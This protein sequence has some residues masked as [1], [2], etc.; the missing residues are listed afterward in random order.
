[1]VILN[2]LSF[3]IITYYG[4]KFLFNGGELR[5]PL[6]RDERMLLDGPEMFWC[7]T[8]STGLLAFSGNVGLDIMAVRL[9]VL[10]VFCIMGVCM[11]PNKPVWTWPLAMYVVYLIWIIAGCLYSPSFVYGFRVFLKYLYPLL[12]CLFASAAVC[13]IEVALKASLLARTVALVS[14]VFVM[15]LPLELMILPGVFWYA[16]ARCIHYISIMIL[17]LGLY[18]YTDQKKKNLFYFILFWVPCFFW[19]FRTSIMGSL[20]AVM[21]FYFIRYHIR[22]LPIIFGIIALGIASVFTIPSLRDKMFHGKNISLEDFRQGKVSNDDINTNA[23]A[24]MWESMENRFYK[25]HEIAGSGTGAV[26]NYMYNNFVFGGLRVVHSDFVQM[27][28]DNG[29]VGFSLYAV[30]MLLIFLHAVITYWSS[31]DNAVKLMAVVAGASLL[32]VFVTLYSDNVVN[33]SMATL[34]MP[35]GFYGMMLGIKRNRTT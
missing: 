33:Y 28:C 7:L 9:L 16:T 12:L 32:G 8:F 4:Y 23:R 29:L 5:S 15:F 17:S 3:F 25:D 10:E 30:A 14:L 11:A 19:V 27:R 6:N 34:S 22:S 31:R 13:N 18:Y 2:L 24:A 1:M 26:Q 21:A 20:V 35:F